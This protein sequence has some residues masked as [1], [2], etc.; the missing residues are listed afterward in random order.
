MSGF[1]KDYFEK[2]LLPSLKVVPLNYDAA[3]RSLLKQ[4]GMSLLDYGCGDGRFVEYAVSRG[5]DAWGV[6][7]SS[8]SKMVS[9]IPARHEV[10]IDGKIPKSFGRE[11]YDLC[12]CCGVLQ[13]MEEGEIKTFLKYIPSMCGK[14][15]IETLTDCSNEVPAVDDSYNKPLR[16]RTWYNKLFTSNGFK[17]TRVTPVYYKNA[18]L[19]ERFK[20]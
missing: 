2:I 8:Y 1:E 12:F 14:I 10:L 20:K 11:H 16:T 7:I 15:W 17:T 18:W 3:L 13:Y 6:D 4:T 9:D 5:I 19:L